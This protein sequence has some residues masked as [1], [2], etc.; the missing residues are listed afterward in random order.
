MNLYVFQWLLMQG[1]NKLTQI[2]Q[3]GKGFIVIV[4]KCLGET[5]CHKFGLVTF[6]FTINPMF[7]FEH[8]FAKNGLPTLGEWHQG[9]S[10][11]DNKKI[12]FFLHGN[13]LLLC[14]FAFQG[15]IH[16][17]R[18]FRKSYGGS[19]HLFNGHSLHCF[20]GLFFL[21]ILLWFIPTFILWWNFFFKRSV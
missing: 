12:I 21:S 1:Y 15:L 4:S 10:V 5:S 20:W 9:P 7:D 11:V 8:P 19:F 13:L 2:L 14:I 17:L 16:N 3:Q 18:F 6:K